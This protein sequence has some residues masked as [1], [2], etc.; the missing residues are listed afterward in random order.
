MQNSL[1][2][3]T[4]VK[5]GE[6]FYLGS[7][8]WWESG[9]ITLLF[10]A[11]G[12]HREDRFFYVPERCMQGGGRLA[13]IQ[14]RRWI[15][16]R[17]GAVSAAW[18]QRNP[19]KVLF[20]GEIFHHERAL[21]FAFWVSASWWGQNGICFSSI[22]LDFLVFLFLGAFVLFWNYGPILFIVWFIADESKI[23]S[24]LLF[25]SGAK[26]FFLRCLLM[27]LILNRIFML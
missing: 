22:T 26:S 13:G 12:L 8:G 27:S 21:R 25:V 10:I 2:L 20:F 6:H 5:S 11:R 19:F 17:L 4:E 16:H 24:R 18:L 23:F 7:H 14:I 3:W 1:F 9:N 15:W